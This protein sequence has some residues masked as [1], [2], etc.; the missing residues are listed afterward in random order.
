MAAKAKHGTRPAPFFP[1]LEPPGGLAAAR[2]EDYTT[3]VAL[4]SWCRPL[5]QNQSP[6]LADIKRAEQDVRTRPRTAAHSGQ[7][8]TGR[9]RQGSRISCL[10]RHAPQ[11][12]VASSRACSR[13]PRAV[14]GSV[15][16]AR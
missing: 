6:D 8:P 10:P 14:L 16:D 4:H 5:H 15:A 9:E 12:L 3:G 1:D 13:P 2:R 7:R 11:G